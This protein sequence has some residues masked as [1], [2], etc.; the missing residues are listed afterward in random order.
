MLSLELIWAIFYLT[1]LF[2]LLSRTQNSWYNNYI[3]ATWVHVVSHLNVN[4]NRQ[5]ESNT[6]ILLPLFQSRQIRSSLKELYETNF[7][8]YCVPDIV[9]G[10]LETSFLMSLSTV[11]EVISFTSVSHM[12]KL[13][14][15]ER[16]RAAREIIQQSSD[17]DFSSATFSRHCLL[18]FSPLSYQNLFS[19]LHQKNLNELFC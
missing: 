12:K 7:W 3:M 2:L 14:F 9:S 19:P 18:P 8:V 5:W 16:K 1:S 4:Q 11:L 17:I 13:R 15:T 10:L 6:K